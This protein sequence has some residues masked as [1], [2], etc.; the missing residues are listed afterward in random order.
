V[1]FGPEVGS[2]MTRVTERKKLPGK[3]HAGPLIVEE[4][5]STTVIPPGCSALVNENSCI[6]ITILD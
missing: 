4:Y 2:K 1:Y 6:V 3:V 5:D